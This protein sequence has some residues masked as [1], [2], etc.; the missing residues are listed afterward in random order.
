[1]FPLCSIERRAK[2]SFVEGLLEMPSVIYRLL[3]HS[4]DGASGDMSELCF[5]FFPLIWCLEGGMR[6]NNVHSCKNS[7]PFAATRREVLTRRI[8]ELG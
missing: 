6:T 8:I 7:K 2:Q 1:M 4:T 3:I 5:I